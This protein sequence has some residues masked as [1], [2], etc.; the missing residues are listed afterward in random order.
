MKNVQA[1][2]SDDDRRGDEEPYAVCGDSERTVSVTLWVL[3][4]EKGDLAVRGEYFLELM[5]GRPGAVSNC[6]VAR[7][8]PSER[9]FEMLELIGAN[10]IEV[11]TFSAED[12]T[13]IG[14]GKKKRRRAGMKT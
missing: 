4:A 8:R 5:T 14:E 7:C 10:E 11:R 13:Q 9:V 3:F 2:E 6:Y 12:I 1:A